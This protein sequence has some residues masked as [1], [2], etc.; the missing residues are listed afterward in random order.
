MWKWG[1]RWLL[2]EKAERQKIYNRTVCVDFSEWREWN[3]D[4][5][6][7]AVIIVGCCSAVYQIQKGNDTA[8]GMGEICHRGNA[9]VQKSDG[10]G[11]GCFFCGKKPLFQKHD[12]YL[13][14]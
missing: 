8:F 3:R 6:A 2:A 10:D 13:L 9:C 1:E 4:M 5:G 11:G 12:T 7:V 14:F